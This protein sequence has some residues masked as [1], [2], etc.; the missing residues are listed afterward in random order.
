MKQ[1]TKN[2]WNYTFTP[3]YAFMAWCSDKAQGQLYLYLTST[4]II[5]LRVH[6]KVR[7][8]KLSLCLTKHHPTTSY[9]EAEEQLHANLTSALDGGV[10]PW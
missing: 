6:Y 9:G 4:R 5:Y 8:V 3:Q 10:Q 2:A 1:K 7:Q